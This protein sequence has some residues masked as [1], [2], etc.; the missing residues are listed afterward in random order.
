MKCQQGNQVYRGVMSALV[1]IQDIHF[2]LIIKRQFLRY[3]ET[4]LL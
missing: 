3:L 4:T 1:Q 2:S